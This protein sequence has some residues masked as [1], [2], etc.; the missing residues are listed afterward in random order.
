MKTSDL[1]QFC[2]PC[3]H[4]DRRR[5]YRGRIRERILNHFQ[6]RC[7]I[8]N[9]HVSNLNHWLEIHHIWPHYS[10]GP[11]DEQNGLPLCRDLCHPLADQGAWSPEYLLDL[12]REPVVRR[13]DQLPRFAPSDLR[14]SILAVDADNRTVGLPWDARIRHLIDQWTMISQNHRTLGLESHLMLSAHVL[15]AISKVITTY[16]PHEDRAMPWWRGAMP[17][18]RITGIVLADR[19]RRLIRKLSPGSD[20]EPLVLG[21]THTLS[22]HYRSQGKY[23]QARDQ[24]RRNARTLLDRDLATAIVVDP[25]QRAY[26]LTAYCVDQAQLGQANARNS[27]ETAIQW[28][29]ESEDL[30]SVADT[31]V[32]AAEVELRLGDPVACLDRLERRSIE[33]CGWD[34]I[35]ADEPIV[36]AIAHKVAGQACVANTDLSKG[37]QHY[38]EAIELATQNGL[39]DQRAK[40]EILKRRMM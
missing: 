6:H 25:A 16:A 5:V 21:I 8:C 37:L 7:A 36:R 23:R 12:V 22:V 19:A 24:Y 3:W 31:I 4:A 40:V 14:D 18:S 38:D 13:V 33:G 32:R 29:R 1:I 10:G 17:P 35:N 20:M 9:R 34:L 11:S 30:H 27:I 28:A 26:L 2:L 39:E 15:W